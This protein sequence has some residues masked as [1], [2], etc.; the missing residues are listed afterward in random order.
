METHIFNVEMTCEGCS[1]AVKRVLGKLGDSVENVDIDMEKKK[2][3]VKS[4]LSSDELLSVIKKTGKNTIY[5]GVK[6]NL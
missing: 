2:V 5:E 4:G 1:G 3:Y 6:E